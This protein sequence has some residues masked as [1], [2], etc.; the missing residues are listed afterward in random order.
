VKAILGQKMNPVG[1]LNDIYPIVYEDN[2][3]VVFADEDGKIFVRNK[4][5]HWA[6][7]RI[8]PIGHE[9]VVTVSVPT[10]MFPSEMDGLPVF[11]VRG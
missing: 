3:I 4:I 5:D 8:F 1:K 10:T 11:R 6:Q 2:K 9:L 7:V